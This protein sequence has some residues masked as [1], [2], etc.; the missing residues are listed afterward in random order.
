MP[1]GQA[2]ITIDKELRED[3]KAIYVTIGHMPCRTKRTFRL[4]ETVQGIVE[5]RNDG[6]AISTE[7][8]TCHTGVLVQI[9]RAKEMNSDWSYGI[10]IQADVGVFV[11]DNNGLKYDA[12][13]LEQN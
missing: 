5:G 13:I 9:F 4:T 1:T 3:P 12:D 11:K 6:I 7:C 2:P 8:E 10:P